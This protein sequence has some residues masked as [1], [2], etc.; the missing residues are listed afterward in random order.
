MAILLA[1]MVPEHRAALFAR[2][3]GYGEARVISGVHFP[4]VGEGGHV[5]GTPV[6]YT[7]LRAHETVLDLGCRIL[8]E[9]K[10]SRAREEYRR[11][12]HPHVSTPTP[13]SDRR[14]SEQ[15]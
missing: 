2:G 5:L 11:R 12:Q 1:Q 15:V 13:T 6:S 14:R 3:W 8:L 10:I 9:K 4:T 7:H